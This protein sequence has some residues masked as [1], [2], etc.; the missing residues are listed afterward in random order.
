MM[1]IDEFRRID[2]EKRKI[3]PKIFLMSEPDRVAGVT[4][5]LLVEKSI[6]VCLPNTY[7][8]F[9]LKYGGGNFGLINVFSAVPESEFYLPRKFIQAEKYLPKNLIPFSDDFSGGN[10]VVLVEDGEALERV[11]YWNI[12]GGLVETGFENILEYVSRYA[13]GDGSEQI[14]L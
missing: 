4:D 5:I 13:Y 1:T 12:D 2:S 10:Y 8:D 3:R 6:G 9:L 7:K 14:A 11:F